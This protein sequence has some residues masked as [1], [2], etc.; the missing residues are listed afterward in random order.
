MSEYKKILEL[1]ENDLISQA[2]WGFVF[3]TEERP[4]WLGPSGATYNGDVRATDI[5]TAR[6]NRSSN[7]IPQLTLDTN[8]SLLDVQ[9]GD[10]IKVVG[11][12]KEDVNDKEAYSIPYSFPGI[13]H[14]TDLNFQIIEKNSNWKQKKIS[15]TLWRARNPLTFEL[16][17]LLDFQD[18]ILL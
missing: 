7:G 2:N 13:T 5:A 8:L 10:L 18:L 15:W 16:D 1:I 12:P 3:Y 17:S 9:V 6:I 4:L 14:V 11:E